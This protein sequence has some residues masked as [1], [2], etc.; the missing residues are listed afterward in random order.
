MSTN[1]IIIKSA[2]AVVATAGLTL[3]AY[4]G[5][6]SSRYGGP[7]VYDYESGGKCTT[8][9]CMQGSHQGGQA[10][11]Y[12]SGNQMQHMQ[13][14]PASSR[15]GGSCGSTV[16]CGTPAPTQSYGY[17]S[18]L[19]VSPGVVYVDCAAMGTCAPQAQT[20]TYQAPA[21]QYVQPTTYAQQSY[22]AQ[23]YSAPA[24]NCP[25]GTTMQADGTCMQ[26]SYSAPTTSYSAPTTSYGSSSSYSTGS[27]SYGGE[28]AACPSGTVT[29]ADGTCMQ[30]GSSFGTTSSYGSGSSFSSGSSYSG[31][32][33]GSS[34]VGASMPTNCPAGTTAQSDG[35]CMEGGSVSSYAGGTATIY[36]GDA[37]TSTQSY[38]GYTSD[39]SYTANSYLPIRK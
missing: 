29:Q 32:T 26:Q 19:P 21:Q 15:Y 16:G 34:S 7:S 9:S 35:T 12:Q 14:A 4:A 6:G 25:S 2:F 5:N 28:T 20:Q 22:S 10:G 31:S 24:A 18:S 13:T 38:G 27:T 17:Q 8:A 3:T 23:T 39:G 33:Y 30:S 37:A 36:S 1:N 11:R